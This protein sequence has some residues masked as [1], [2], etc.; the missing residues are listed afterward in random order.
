MGDYPSQSTVWRSILVYLAV[1]LLGL[2]LAAANAFAAP[3][4]EEAGEVVTSPETFGVCKAADVASTVYLLEHGWAVE[5][6]PIV[7]WSMHI[8]GYMPLVFVSAGLYWAF[9]HFKD[10]PGMPLATGA[11]NVVTCGV[12]AHNLLLIP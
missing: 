3:T 1:C 10:E 2:M 6:N 5:G 4:L 7:A 11:A 12:A 8:G 9:S